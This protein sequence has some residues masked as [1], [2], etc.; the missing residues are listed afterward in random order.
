MIGSTDI[1]KRFADDVYHSLEDMIDRCGVAKPFTVRF[2][3]PDGASGEEVFDSVNR[4]AEHEEFVI[5][6]VDFMHEDCTDNTLAVDITI[7]PRIKAEA[8]IDIGDG[9][10]LHIHEEEDLEEIFTEFDLAVAKDLEKKRKEQLNE[11][12]ER[13]MGTVEGKE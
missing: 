1:A 13:A 9:W 10:T 11:K 7:R 12:Y 4:L 8:T 3:V 2:T 5:A 6:R